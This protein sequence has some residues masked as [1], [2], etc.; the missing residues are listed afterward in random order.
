MIR[1]TR[2]EIEVL[3]TT[4]LKDENGK[5]KIGKQEIVLHDVKEKDV[6]KALKRKYGENFEYEIQ[7]VEKTT[8]VMTKELFFETATIELDTV[9]ELAEEGGN[10]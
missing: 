3:V 10:E 6:E 7:N 4:A 8:Y 9:E 2:I 5:L 1:K